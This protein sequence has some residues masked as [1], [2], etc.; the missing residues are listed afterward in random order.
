MVYPNLGKKERHW[1]STRN[2]V[3]Q[4]CRLYRALMVYFNLGKKEHHK[5][6]TFK[7]IPQRV[8]HTL[9]VY[10]NLGK[11]RNATGVLHVMA[12]FKNVVY[13]L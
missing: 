2:G 10:S 13:I 8:C 11:K 1:R 6:T 4:V 5:A 9:M 7:C 12:F 3:P